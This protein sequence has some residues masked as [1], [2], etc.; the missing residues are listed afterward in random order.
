MRYLPAVL[1]TALLGACSSNPGPNT[2]S[3]NLEITVSASRPD[4]VRAEAAKAIQARGFKI[5]S[6]ADG[7]I[8]A[9]YIRPEDGI[10]ERITVLFLPLYGTKTMKIVVY[11]DQVKHPGADYET[12]SPIRPTQFGQDQL[13]MAKNRIQSRCSTR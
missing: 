6:T 4:C 3:G 11:P 7:R 1:F 2:P 10:E 12:Y 8:I 5:E 9:G 13:D